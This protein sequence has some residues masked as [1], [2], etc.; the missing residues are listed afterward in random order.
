MDKGGVKTHAVNDKAQIS[1]EIEQKAA[2]SKRS[3]GVISNK[4]VRSVGND[5]TAKAPEPRG[6]PSA[7]ARRKE[8]FSKKS[9]QLASNQKYKVLKNGV[10]GN[11][12]ITKRKMRVISSKKAANR[13]FAP[14]AQKRRTDAPQQRQ[15]G[16]K[17]K[18][19]KL[20]K[21]KKQQKRFNREQAEL[22]GIAMY[23]FAPSKKPDITKTV[24]NVKKAAHI[25]GKPVESL[26]LQF[27]S[28]TDKSDDN[29]DY[30]TTRIE[31]ENVRAK[32]VNS[33]CL[34]EILCRYPR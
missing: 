28:H 24:A 26:K 32:C 3:D 12:E 1:H 22:I 33:P 6:S 10:V 25:V 5:K 34:E 19:A 27:Y 4:N 14:F 8:F 13:T 31:A 30:L 16:A 23:G 29:G 21:L 18:K 17:L 7:A 20:K 2:L 9:P 15:T 11:N